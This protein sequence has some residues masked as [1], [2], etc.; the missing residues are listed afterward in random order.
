MQR[1]KTDTMSFEALVTGAVFRYPYLWKQQADRG[2]TEGRKDRPVAV[3]FRIGRI[4]DLE[5]IVVIP[6]TSKVPEAG[7]SSA[8]IP[9]VEKRR[10]GLDPDMRLWIILDEANM[11]VLGRSYYLAEQKPLGEFSKSYFLPIVREFAKNFRSVMKVDR[12][13]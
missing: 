9:E 8:E 3:A 13:R 11:D 12:T 4:D 1:A 5:T 2:E 7:R 6:I 10:A